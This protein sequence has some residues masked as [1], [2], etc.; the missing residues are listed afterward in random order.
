MVWEIVG[1]AET[2]GIIVR[3]EKS[4][5][6]AE[7]D[8]RLATG[9]RVQEVKLQGDRL[10]YRKLEGAGPAEGWI[11]TTSRGKVLAVRAPEPEEF[12]EEFTEGECAEATVIPQPIS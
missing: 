9:A 11:S 12:P 2:G 7:L 5:K 6:S 1:G 4:S 3:E 10:K 8:A